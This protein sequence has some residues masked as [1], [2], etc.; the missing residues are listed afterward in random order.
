M[1]EA[2]HL[3][4]WSRF[5]IKY[6][7]SET[8]AV[9]VENFIRPYVRQDSYC[10]D[11]PDGSYTISSLYLDNN[12]LKLC[13]ESLDGKANRFK[14]RIRSYNDEEDSP[15]FFE[16]KRR[17]NSVI[18]KSRAKV[19]RQYFREF[20]QGKRLNLDVVGAN[21]VAL[22][23]FLLYRDAL[24]ANGVIKIRYKRKA[25]E[26]LVD[27]RVR[28]TFDREICCNMTKS[29]DIEVEGNHWQKIT[30]RN[31][32][33]EIKFTGQYPPW[34]SRMAEL[35]GLKQQSL[36]KYTTTMKQAAMLRYAAPTYSKYNVKDIG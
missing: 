18:V 12:D 21:G 19:T 8:M 3:A 14:L 5:E 25:Y 27:D 31:V 6:M 36:S 9:A 11:Q 2:S 26:G 10:L 17:I 34:L 23:Q 24:N 7:I 13:Y 22:N 20:A 4:T 15:V 29:W 16:I 28:I 32:V 35:L 1:N 33:L 30:T